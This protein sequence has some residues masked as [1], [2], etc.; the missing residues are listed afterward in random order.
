MFIITHLLY[1]NNNYIIYLFYQK[2]NV[3]ILVHVFLMI[4]YLIIPNIF[5][6]F[7][8]LFIPNFICAIDK[9]YPILNKYLLFL[10]ITII[11]YILI[12]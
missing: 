2:Y 8:N 9:V 12:L 10:I 1:I 11:F 3:I 6:E 7:G 4:F 5:D